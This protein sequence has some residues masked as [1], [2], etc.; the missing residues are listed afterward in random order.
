MSAM[1]GGV[2]VKGRRGDIPLDRSR[3]GCLGWFF[4]VLSLL[5]VIPVVTAAVVARTQRGR[6]FIEDRMEKWLGMDLKVGET[7]LGLPCT[8]LVRKIE[9]DDVA[10]SGQ[11]MFQVRE[12]QLSRNLLARRWDVKVYRPALNLTKKADGSWVP[13]FFSRLGEL[14]LLETADLGRLTRGLRE[15]VALR[16]EDG[17]VRWMEDGGRET[18]SAEGITFGLTP[19]HVPGR[20]MYHYAVSIQSVLGKDGTRAYDVER[21][22]LCSDTIECLELQRSDRTRP[23]T[24][25][26]PREGTE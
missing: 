11:P 21:E 20:Q 25:R 23:A 13:G 2:D 12:L 4:L 26:D 5:V 10:P 7:S 6:L 16:V 19:V 22:W 8:L 15:R 18:A 9:S 24:E 1:E 17:S 3:M 14:P